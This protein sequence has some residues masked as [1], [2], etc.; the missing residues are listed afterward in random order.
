MSVAQR[1]RRTV[2]ELSSTTKTDPFYE[3][4]VGK[5]GGIGDKGDGCVSSRPKERKDREEEKISERHEE[6]SLKVAEL[7]LIKNLIKIVKRVS[8]GPTCILERT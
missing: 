7:V 4:I 5:R 3:R 6:R 8:V 1:S 2:F